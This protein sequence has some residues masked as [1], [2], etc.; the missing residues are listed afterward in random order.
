MSAPARYGLDDPAF[1]GRLRQPPARREAWGYT[2]QR[3]AKPALRFDG[4]IMAGRQT[5]PKAN[6]PLPGQHLLVAPQPFAKPARPKQ[7]HSAVL[8]RQAVR[9]PVQPD[10]SPVEKPRRSRSQLALAGLAAVI[11]VCGLAVSWQT[12]QTNHSASAQVAALSKRADK[13]GAPNSSLPSTTKPSDA[14]VSQYVVAPDLPRY[15]NIPKLNVHARVMQVGVTTD[16]ALG[17]P[18]NVHDTAWYTGSAKPGQPGATLIDGHVSSWTTRGVFYGLK[19]LVAG[20]N[21]QIVRGDG[22]VFN[23][24]VVK[25]AVYP[26]DHVDMQAAITP[27]TAGKPGLNLITCTGQVNKKSSTFNQRI[28]VFTQQV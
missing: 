9:P 12:L 8:Q 10:P 22:A 15:L 17:T 11:A 13:N 23:Y 24:Q 14:A 18:S 19:N 4:Q 16:G 7:Q 25:T 3:P 26:A 2:G 6:G 1:R 20:D 27:V 28:I 5:T 21:L